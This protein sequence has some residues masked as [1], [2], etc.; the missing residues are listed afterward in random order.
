MYTAS[1]MHAAR[2][3]NALRQALGRIGGCNPTVTHN[4]AEGVGDLHIDVRLAPTDA[5]KLLDILVRIKP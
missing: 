2:I 5:E 3:A 4:V 1:E